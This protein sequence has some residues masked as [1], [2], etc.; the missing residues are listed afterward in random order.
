MGVEEH[1]FSQLLQLAMTDAVKRQLPDKPVLDD[2]NVSTKW[3]RTE[4]A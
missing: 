3:H 2:G 1:Q 4:E